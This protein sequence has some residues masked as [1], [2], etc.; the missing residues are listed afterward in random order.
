MGL[1]K[2]EKVSL[3]QA[4]IK[5]KYK[6]DW[7]LQNFVHYTNR[8]ITIEGP[9]GLI[10]AFMFFSILPTGTL[11]ILKYQE[12]DAFGASLHLLGSVLGMFQTMVNHDKYHADV[13][14]L[15]K[16][17]STSYLGWLWRSAELKRI[18]HEH[19]LHH[20]GKNHNRYFSMVPFDCFFLYPF[21]P[22]EHMHPT[23]LATMN[24]VAESIRLEIGTAYKKI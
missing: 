21:W 23:I 24:M 20:D 9:V 15:E 22:E 13:E 2:L 17:A 1:A 7:L 14:T 18:I 8:G 6:G 16:Y 11:S 12:G 10:G 4:E 19:K 5:E 3:T